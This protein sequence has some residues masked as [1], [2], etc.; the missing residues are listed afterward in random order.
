MTNTIAIIHLTSEDFSYITHMLSTSLTNTKITQRPS[1]IPPVSGPQE[2]TLTTRYGNA[3]LTLLPFESVD[4]VLTKTVNGYVCSDEVG[5]ENLKKLPISEPAIVCGNGDNMDW[6][7]D[8]EIEYINMLTETTDLDNVEG[9]ERII[10]AIANTPWDYKPIQTGD[11]NSNNSNNTN[12]CKKNNSESKTQIPLF[13][14]DECDHDLE[15]VMKS[16]IDFK[17]KAA[18]TQDPNQ[19]REFAEE[20]ALLLS[21][22]LGESDDSESGDTESGDW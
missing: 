4:Q 9:R 21:N 19:R 20:A 15:T 1:T 8:N 11:N 13:C 22:F 2:V 6:C 5:L 14:G 16:L 3:T 10:E 18:Q 7:I 17:N 12:G